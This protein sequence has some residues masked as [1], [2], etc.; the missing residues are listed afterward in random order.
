MPSG[1]R[2]KRLRSLS[3]AFGPTCSS[4]AGWL[5]RRTGGAKSASVTI[6]GSSRRAAPGASP[7]LIGSL[8]EQMS[9]QSACVAY[10][11]IEQLP[12]IDP[13]SATRDLAVPSRVLAKFRKVDVYVRRG[14]PTCLTRQL[15]D[16]NCFGVNAAPQTSS[17]ILRVG[18]RFKVTYRWGLRDDG[19]WARPGAHASRFR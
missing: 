13:D 4:P 12:N 9:C 19:E 7:D 16:A 6:P 11:L 18:D 1:G 10:A 14:L 2:W 8:M 17:G 5:G 3:S 15:G